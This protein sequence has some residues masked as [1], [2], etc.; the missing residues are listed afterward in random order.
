[1]E[2]IKMSLPNN[3]HRPKSGFWKTEHGK[4]LW[5]ECD[6]YG[7]L[8]KTYEPCELMNISPSASFK[9][10]LVKEVMDSEGFNKRQQ[11]F[12]QDVSIRLNE[13]VD[14]SIVILYEPSSRKYFLRDL[15]ELG[16]TFAIPLEQQP[17]NVSIIE[18]GQPYKIS[19]IEAKEILKVSGYGFGKVETDTNGNISEYYVTV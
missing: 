11:L 9:I 17:D 4:T 19:Q 12:A 10:I 5:W 7:S 6:D 14:D 13:N 3:H 16:Q 18:K 2:I 15:K 1:M 8:L